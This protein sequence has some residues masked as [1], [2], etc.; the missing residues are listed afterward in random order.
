[1][2][3]EKVKELI[4]GGESQTVEFK[5]LSAGQLG[6]SLFDTVSAFANRHG[7]YILVGVADDGT[8]SGVNSNVC[9]GLRRNFA[10]RVSNPEV[11]FPP[12]RRP[13]DDPL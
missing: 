3:A 5:S 10:N 6:D 11:I 13:A 7:G 9:E 2:L 1:M 12:L 4:A 8:I